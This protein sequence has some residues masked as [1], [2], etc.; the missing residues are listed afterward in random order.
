MVAFHT[1]PTG[2]LVHDPGVGS[3]WE[4]NQWPFGSQAGTQLTE[5]GSLVFLMMAVVTL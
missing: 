4:L 2:D 1:P 5:P 3:D